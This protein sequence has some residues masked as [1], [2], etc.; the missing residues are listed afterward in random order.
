MSEAGKAEIEGGIGIIEQGD[1][2]VIAAIHGTAL[3]GARGGLFRAG[4]T[5]PGAVPRQHLWSSKPRR[6]ALETGGC[7]D[8]AD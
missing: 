3:V 2:P 6:N 8:R 7:D 5:K 4:A 1:K